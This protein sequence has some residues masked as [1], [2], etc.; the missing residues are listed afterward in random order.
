[1][2]LT[3][4]IGLTQDDTEDESN[5]LTND[6]EHRSFI[7]TALAIKGSVTPK[8][9]PRVLFSGLYASLVVWAGHFFPE[10]KLS[11]T[12]FEYSGVVLGL[13]LVARV[14]AGMDRWWEARKMWGSIVNQ[15]RNLAVIGY[16]YSSADS[17]FLKG[18]LRW[19][20]L[21]P[22]AIKEHLR[23]RKTLANGARLVGEKKPR[24][25][26]PLTP[27]ASLHWSTNRQ[28]SQRNAQTWPR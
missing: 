5:R 23:D 12:P 3:S 15:S 11:I 20:A 18:F 1:M 17:P 28:F 24:Q 9:M 25:D 22:Y 10:L 2:E 8:V 7:K 26:C 27:Y 6:L 16:Q 14:N 4:F 13:L 19:V 21:W